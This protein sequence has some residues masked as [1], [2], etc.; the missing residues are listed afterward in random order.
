MRPLTYRDNYKICHKEN[1]K[2]PC[3]HLAANALEI[4]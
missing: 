4:K 2:K 3:N 1:N